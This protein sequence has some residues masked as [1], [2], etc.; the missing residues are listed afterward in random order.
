MEVLLLIIF[1]AFSFLIRLTHGSDASSDEWVSF[2]LIKR[3][4]NSRWINYAVPDAANPGIYPYPQL[5]HFLIAKLP[6]KYWGIGGRCINAIWDVL[7]AMIVYWISSRLFSSDITIAGLSAPLSA[8]ILLLTMPILLPTNARM[9]TIKGRSIGFFLT[10]VY[11][12]F[13]MLSL[14]GYGYV[15]LIFASVIL[16]LIIVS[17]MFALQVAVLFSLAVCL[18][19][20]TATPLLPVGAS[21]LVSLLFAKLGAVQAL[22]FFLNHKRL[23]L[24]FSELG[25]TAA[26]R[27]RIE[28]I[29]RLPSRLVKSPIEA[30][31]TLFKKNTVFISLYS[32]PSLFF[33]VIC[34]LGSENFRQGIFQDQILLFSLAISA[35]S[36]LVFLFV[37]IPR[38]S[39]LGQAERYFEYSSPFIVLAAVSALSL[40][41]PARASRFFWLLFGLQLSGVFINAV[42]VKGT[43]LIRSSPASPPGLTE[44]S[45]WLQ[46]NADEGRIL[47]VPI[48][49]SFLL[50]HF[51]H[52][53]DPHTKLRF[54]YRFLLKEGE[55]EF[56]SYQNLIG[57]YIFSKGVYSPNFEMPR[58]SPSALSAA[59]G[60][61][62]V[63]IDKRPMFFEGIN[64]T[65]SDHDETDSLNDPAFEN[66]QFMICKIS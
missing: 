33:V 54:Y 5:P 39:F 66:E 34:F 50:E 47:T 10:T 9:Q 3:Q 60:I 63:V 8:V 51:V 38:F 25:T 55:R 19:Y 1:L 49:L 65:W 7:V 64:K 30:I 44:A 21:F 61:T 13:L 45:D 37:S 12:L 28:D 53:S 29:L 16:L 17:S 6:E 58:L 43:S 26:G 32:V 22:A 41:S 27:N 14:F 35:A 18:F 11:F 42:L 57:G 59:L 4:Q 62:H 56:E 36:L 23:Y 46:A 20:R 40:M 31:S 15:Y 2:W 52:A 24:K 48:K